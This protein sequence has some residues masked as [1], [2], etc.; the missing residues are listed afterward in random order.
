MHV[1]ELV[2]VWVCLYVYDARKDLKVSQR[3]E[4]SIFEIISE[5]L[6]KKNKNHE[7][8]SWHDT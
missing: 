7:N 5:I 3:I 8:P 6:K 1:C 2:Y 4:M